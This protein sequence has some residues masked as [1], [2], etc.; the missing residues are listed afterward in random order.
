VKGKTEAEVIYA[1]VGRAGVV[2]S[3]EL[4]SLQDHWAMLRV[5]YRKQDWTG[6]LKM[7]D[8]CRCECERF[9]LV[10]LID[11]YADRI[12]RLE[13]RSPTSEWDGVFTA[14]TK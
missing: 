1:I 2:K 3:P 7:I 14:E 4:R 13:Q 5:C 9:G 11:A 10:G 6:A 12:R 8:V